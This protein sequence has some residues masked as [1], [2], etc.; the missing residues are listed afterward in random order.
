MEEVELLADRVG[1]LRRGEL[2]A[3]GTPADIVERTGQPNLA[4]AFLA[5][6]ASEA[7]A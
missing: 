4:R 3:E 2:V 7:P 1:V 5:L 6:V